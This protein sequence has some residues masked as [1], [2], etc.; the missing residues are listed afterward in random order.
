M[1]DTNI[2]LY[3]MTFGMA[4]I[5]GIVRNVEHSSTKIT[6]T[7][8]DSTGRI[9]AHL[10]LEEGD[11]VNQPNIIT[12]TYARVFGALRAQ[13]G[14]KTIMLFK[15]VPVETAN[16]VTTHMLEVLMTRYK[17]EDLTNNGVRAPADAGNVFS[18][19]TNNNEHSNGLQGKEK[20]IFDAVKA[21]KGDTGISIKELQGK[22]G[23]ISE[24]EIRYVDHGE[25][26]NCVWKDI[27]L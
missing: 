3:G 20:M 26:R 24:S 18:D 7:M 9:E 4:T 17:A 22:F 19:S 23:S 2:S 21:F 12:N 16:E 8:E 15:I 14:G 10:W 1:Q 11:N 5:V 25:R 6:Y 13:G 27:N